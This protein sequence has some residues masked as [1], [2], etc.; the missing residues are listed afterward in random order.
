MTDESK[1]NGGFSSIDEGK[2]S[3]VLQG[4]GARER[5]GII[6]WLLISFLALCALAAVTGLYFVRNIKVREIRSGNDVQV[7][8][9]LGSIHVQH[10]G[11]G[12]YGSGGIPVYPGARPLHNGESATV[13]LSGILGADNDF[14]IVAGKWLTSDPIDKV[15]R[16]YENKFPHMSVIQHH[17]KVEMH[18]AEGHSKRVIALCDKGGSTEIALASVGEPKAN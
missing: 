8:T 7:D 12:R 13:D 2:K 3:S 18:D 16:Y 10:N 9:P 15:Q 1:A 17:G 4:R 14:H 5:G 6:A 11:S